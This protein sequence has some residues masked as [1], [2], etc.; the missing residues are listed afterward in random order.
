ALTTA[1]FAAAGA[2]GQPT[3]AP[4]PTESPFGV[5]QAFGFLREKW[6]GDLDEIE[7]REVRVIRVLTAYNKTG[8]FLDGIDQKGINADAFEEFE[9]WINKRQK[10]TNANRIHV[11]VIPVPRNEL[12][13]S[14]VD[15]RGDLASA[16]L[17]ITPERLLQVDFSSPVL[18]EV[19]EVPVTHKSGPAL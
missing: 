7:K 12:L 14:L 2:A 3:P 1:L 5:E 17:T 6:T 8:Y 16:N 18:D 15:G 9:R 19:D 11:V 4:T 10:T 13:Q